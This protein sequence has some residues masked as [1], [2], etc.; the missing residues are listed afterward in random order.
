MVECT[1]DRLENLEREVTDGE[2]KMAMF[3]IG[4][5]RAPGLTGYS[6]CFFQE[7][8]VYRWPGCLSGC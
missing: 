1:M 7:V 2:I 3:D 8:L 6:S 5:D 4:Q